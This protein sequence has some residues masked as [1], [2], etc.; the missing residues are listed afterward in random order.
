MTRLCNPRDSPRLQRRATDLLRRNWNIGTLFLNEITTALHPVD[1]L[2]VASR[3]AV[4][5]PKVQSQD[6]TL[7]IPTARD[8]WIVREGETTEGLRANA[9]TSRP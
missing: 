5:V 1:Q 2:L 8:S 3:P 9:G 7:H 6:L 4:L